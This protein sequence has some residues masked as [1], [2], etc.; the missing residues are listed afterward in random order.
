MSD[1]L[2]PHF[3]LTELTV[4]DTGLDN[5][6]DAMMEATL[7]TLAVFLEKVRAVLGS[8]PVLVDSAYRSP[9]VN[10]ADGGVSDSAHLL[11]YAADITCPAFGTPF[12]VAQALDRA[13]QVGT[14]RFDQLIYEQTWV[15]ISRDPQLRGDRLTLIGEGSYTSGI[16][17][18]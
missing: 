14:I 9:A 3:S 13:D 18:P 10:A 12:E 1:Q 15:H 4:T 2:S 5:T 16:V 8:N 11:G 6:P 7:V 17:G